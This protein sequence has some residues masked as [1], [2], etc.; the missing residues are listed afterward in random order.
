ML[1]QWDNLNKYFLNFIP[2]QKTFK[3][4][5]KETKRYKHIVEMLKAPMTQRSL[6][7]CAF[8]SQDFETF[9]LKFQYEQPMIHMLYTSM[10][11]LLSNL[12]QKFVAKEKFI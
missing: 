2:K 12:M 5:I 6:A 3:Y 1:E 11:E 7:F 10:E 4:T 9:L 8:A